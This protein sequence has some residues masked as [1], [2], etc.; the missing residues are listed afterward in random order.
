M[1][2]RAAEPGDLGA[3]QVKVFH[4]KRP[5]RIDAPGRRDCLRGLPQSAPSGSA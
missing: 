5:Q 2:G 3:K 4:A 1:T